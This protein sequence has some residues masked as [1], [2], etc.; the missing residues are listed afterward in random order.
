MGKFKY[1]LY[2]NKIYVS[3]FLEKSSEYRKVLRLQDRDKVRDT[4]YSEVL[5]LISSYEYGFAKLIEAAFEQKGRKLSSWEVDELFAE[6][7]KLPHWKPLVEKSRNKMASRDLAFR[8]ALHDRLK[9]YITPLNPVEFE[10][11][12]GEK[13]KELAVRLEEAKDVMKRLKERG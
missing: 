8:D 7:E 5:D 11:F 4:F 1:P 10:R 2:T 12:L 9:G 3:I 13:S 6:F